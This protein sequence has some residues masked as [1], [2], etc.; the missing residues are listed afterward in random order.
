MNYE[1]ITTESPK[2]FDSA[3]SGKP[4]LINPDK[5]RFCLLRERSMSDIHSAIDE[6]LFIRNDLHW[7]FLMGQVKGYARSGKRGIRLP[8]EIIRLLAVQKKMGLQYVANTNLIREVLGVKRIL[9]I[10]VRTSSMSI[11]QQ[12]DTARSLKPTTKKDILSFYKTDVKRDYLGHD[13]LSSLAHSSSCSLEF[14]GRLTEAL[15]R[16]IKSEDFQTGQFTPYKKARLLEFLGLA[17]K[18]KWLLFPFVYKSSFLPEHLL[19]LHKNNVAHHCA[20]EFIGNEFSH[21]LSYV[22]EN[23]PH[24]H[25]ARKYEVFAR[26]LMQCS[27]YRQLNQS[28]IDLFMFYIENIGSLGD[29]GKKTSRVQELRAPAFCNLLIQLFNATEDN[30]AKKLPLI[31]AERR[32]KTDMTVYTSFTWMTDSNPALSRWREAFERHIVDVKDS[33]FTERRRTCNVL[34]E[35]L[36]SLTNPPASPDEMPRQLINDYESDS[37]TY[38][39]FLA[40]KFSNDSANRILQLASQFFEWH[41]DRLRKDFKDSPHEIPHYSN[42][43]D[44][45]RDR[46]EVVYRAGTTR[47]AIQ[48]EIMSVM[49]TILVE[50]NYT[51][52]QENFKADYGDLTRSHPE[53]G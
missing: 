2:A 47:K 9:D 11:E 25:A 30:P 22:K 1:Y 53:T 24:I 16:D 51:W 23:A 48:S 8:H 21:I 14:F 44:T 13:Y 31:A 29:D 34:G 41:L 20:P 50:D 5:R 7:S 27:T 45:R 35:F 18:K 32:N 43:I 28:S 26:T 40:S 42:P 38:R 36:L 17:L 10:P 39:N 15:F 12:L 6:H 19:L 49:R 52:P 37:K 4:V 3:M 33:Q 46:F